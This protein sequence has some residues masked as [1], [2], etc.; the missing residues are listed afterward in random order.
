M[1]LSKLK[2][3]LKQEKQYTYSLATLL[4]YKN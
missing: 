4:D 2:S 3:K 1:T